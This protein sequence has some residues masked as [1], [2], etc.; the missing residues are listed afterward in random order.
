MSLYPK[1]RDVHLYAGLAVLI[2]VV[3]ISATGVMLNHK[4]WLASMGGIPTKYED[5]MAERDEHG[6]TATNAD[7]GNFRATND[8]WREHAS[9][10]DLAVARAREAWGGQDVPLDRIELK[11]EQ[12]MMVIKVKAAKAARA[13]PEEF[14]FGVNGQELVET[15]HEG[16]WIKDLHTGKIFSASYGYF[17]S[18]VAGGVLVLLSITGLVLY[19]I[20]LMKKRRKKTK[21]KLSPA[22]SSRGRVLEAARSSRAGVVAKRGAVRLGAESENDVAVAVENQV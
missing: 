3:A 19:V 4:P 20:P 21:G 17:W 13:R 18:D 15:E 10:I 11:N 5:K 6:K 14:V 7:A 12:G 22:P 9:S 8:A 16:D 1:F 2:P